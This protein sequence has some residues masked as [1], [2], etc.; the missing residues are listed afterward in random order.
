MEAVV[1]G[2]TDLGLDEEGVA[3]GAVSLLFGHLDPSLTGIA[4]AR[5]V[6]LVIH[7]G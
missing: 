3:V 1:I 7:V 4:P 6:I 5:P 2:V